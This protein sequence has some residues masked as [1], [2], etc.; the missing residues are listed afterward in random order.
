MSSEPLLGLDQVQEFWPS[1]KGVHDGSRDIN[2][3]TKQ[4]VSEPENNQSNENRE[5]GN[6]DCFPPMYK[7]K[8]YNC[9]GA[10]GTS[11]EFSCHVIS[12]KHLR[13]Y[14]NCLQVSSHL[15]MII[16]W[17]SVL[18]AIACSN[19]VKLKYTTHFQ[20]NFLLFRDDFLK[21]NLTHFKSKP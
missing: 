8:I 5:L 18:S 13:S 4:S 6:K 2:E 20:A 7:C 21:V 10:W 15:G 17:K 3:A 16:E 19:D 1:K 12:I 9:D 11:N 14:F